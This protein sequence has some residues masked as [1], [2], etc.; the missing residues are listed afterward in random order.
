MPDLLLLPA[1]KMRSTA[2][3]LS[4]LS[5]LLTPHD[6]NRFCKAKTS[7]VTHTGQLQDNQVPT[8]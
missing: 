8:C 6:F 1:A 4:K 5:L 7:L 3:A 2:S